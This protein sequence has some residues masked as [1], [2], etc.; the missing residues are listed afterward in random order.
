MKNIK[1]FCVEQSD[2]LSTY[3]CGKFLLFNIQRMLSGKYRANCQ[4]GC[5]MSTKTFYILTLRRIKLKF[6]SFLD[7]CCEGRVS[8]LV[9]TNYFGM[10]IE[11]SLIFKRLKIDLSFLINFH[12][13]I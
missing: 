13:M 10:V 3:M 4:P 11:G 5:I 9:S 1:M 8:F 12:F 6:R 7:F 2:H